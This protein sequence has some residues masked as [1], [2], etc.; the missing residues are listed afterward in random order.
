MSTTLG[1]IFWA[2]GIVDIYLGIYFAWTEKYQDNHKKILMGWLLMIIGLM[3]NSVAAL[4]EF[5][6]LVF[7]LSIVAILFDYYVYKTKKKEYGIKENNI[8]KLFLKE[9]SE[10]KSK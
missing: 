6:W 8:R 5:K 2:I 7:A 10:Y 9:I 1:W 3:F 4:I